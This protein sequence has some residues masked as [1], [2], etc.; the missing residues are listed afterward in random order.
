MFRNAAHRD[1]VRRVEEMGFVKLGTYIKQ[2]DLRN[3][4]G[5]M[6][7][8]AVVGLSTAKQIIPTK[9]NMEGV[10]QIRYRLNVWHIINAIVNFKLS[11]EK[12]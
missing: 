6:N 3:A 2:S 1:L 8:D 11:F 4:D 12:R 5:A 10:S 7:A 9:A